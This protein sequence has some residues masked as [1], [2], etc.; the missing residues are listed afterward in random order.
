MSYL[1]KKRKLG[2]QIKEF[3]EQ[4]EDLGT[5]EQAVTHEKVETILTAFQQDSQQDKMN[6]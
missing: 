5:N 3:E 1:K 6:E 2:K 4:K